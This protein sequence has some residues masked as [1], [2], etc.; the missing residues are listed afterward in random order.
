MRLVLGNVRLWRLGLI[1]PVLHGLHGVGGPLWLGRSLWALGLGGSGGGA[2]AFIERDAV[3]ELKEH[4][5]R[6]W[7]TREANASEEPGSDRRPEG[8]LV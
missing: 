4:A 2:A 8:C 6:S 5:V 7:E 1:L 3:V